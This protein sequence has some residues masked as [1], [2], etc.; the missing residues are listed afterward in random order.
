MTQGQAA[1]ISIPSAE[2]SPRAA[3]PADSEDRLIRPSRF[4]PVR[5]DEETVLRKLKNEFPDREWS[6]ELLYQP[7]LLA[8]TDGKAYPPSPS[9]ARSSAGWLM[10]PR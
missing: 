6:V 4:L 1:G 9:T 8:E 3:S 5:A 10:S 2:S 7:M